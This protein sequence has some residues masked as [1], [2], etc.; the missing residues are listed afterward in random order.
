MHRDIVESVYRFR[1]E[2]L[3]LESELPDQIR[4][5]ARFA[6][7]DTMRIVETKQLSQMH[8][9]VI[10]VFALLAVEAALNEYGYLRFGQPIFDKK[11]EGQSIGKKLTGML[12]QVLGSFEE[13]HE[14]VA[15]VKALAARRNR[16][17]HPKPEME[18][19]SGDGI[20][21]ATTTRLPRVDRD[22]AITAVQEMER[23]FDLMGAIDS[24]AAFRLGFGWPRLAESLHATKGSK[25]GDDIG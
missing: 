3:R 24:E 1:A 12:R 15:V 22:S 8:S 9:R 21:T 23:F 16:L 18:M 6:S 10:Q 20:R 13:S 19:W 7:P 11:F 14:I 2:M 25:S 17:V 5:E 4:F